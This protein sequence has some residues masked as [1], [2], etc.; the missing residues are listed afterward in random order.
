MAVESSPDLVVNRVSVRV[1]THVLVAL[2]VFGLALLPRVLAVGDFWT[3]DEPFHWVQR[4]ETFLQALAQGD[5]ASTN[6]TGHPGVTTMWLGSAGLLLHQ[7]MSHLGWIDP[8]DLA[9][10]RALLRLP[11]AIVTALSIALA[12]PLLLR[13]FGQRMALLATLFWLADPFLVAHSQVL[14]LDA[15]LAS[16]MTLALLAALVAFRLDEPSDIISPASIRWKFLV[17]SGVAG[18]LALLTRSPAIILPPVIGLIGL[19]AIWQHQSFSFKQLTMALLLWGV[20]VLAVWFVVWPANWVDPAGAVMSV[21][22]EVRDNGGVAHE[23]GNFFLGRPV[24]DPGPFFYPVAVALR[25]TPWG[26]IGL[27]VAG[28]VFAWRRSATPGIVV[29]ALFA[30]LFILA[31]SMLSKKMD[32]YVLSVFPA[33][34]I[35]AAWGWIWLVANIWPTLRQRAA[36]LHYP[37]VAGWWA[38][39]G[40]GLGLNLAWYHPYELAYYNPLLGGGPVAEHTM[41]VGWGEGLDQVADFINSETHDCN[42]LVAAWYW[43]LLLDKVCTPLAPLDQAIKSDDVRYAVMYINQL[44]RQSE[45]QTIAALSRMTPIHTVRLHGIDY[46]WIYQIPAPMAQTVEVDF[47]PAIQLQGYSLHTDA[48]RTSGT[49]TV[50]LQ[51]QALGAMAKDYMLFL[52]LLNTE[53][54]LIAQVDVPPG[55]PAAPTHA[56]QP[57]RYITWTHTVPVPADIPPG[58]YQLTLGLYDPADFSRL[59]LHADSSASIAQRDGEHTLLVGVVTVR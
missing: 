18:G 13:L 56:W 21:I 26:L 32:R 3:R 41:L 24:D 11:L 44:Q 42:Q 28:G 30:T 19:L 9:S 53:G 34:N 16:F 38:L 40:L 15:L 49:L 29:M 54:D 1:R 50:T 23:T 6:L 35:L 59:P 5:Y 58:D 27:F 2:F 51:W 17:A 57:H 55:G 43:P 37:G 22:N 45:P 12:Y 4:S 47:G 52:H 8:A 20:V 10:Q 36:L 25:L 31:L 48:I 7:G 46:A 39:V 33:L 14:H